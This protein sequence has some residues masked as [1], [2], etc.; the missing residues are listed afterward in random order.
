MARL[1]VRLPDSLRDRL[2]ERADQE[3]V[4]LNHF[5]VFLLAQASTLDSVRAQR[6]RYG[7]LLDRGT[8]EEAEDALQQVLSERR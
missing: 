7:K 3:G 5:L 8:S 4:S 6:E 2:A 1:T